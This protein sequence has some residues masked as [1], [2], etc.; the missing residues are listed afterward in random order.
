M[1]FCS[2]HVAIRRTQHPYHLLK[3]GVLSVGQGL[4]RRP[5]VTAS[6]MYLSRQLHSVLRTPLRRVLQAALETPGWMLTLG[7][8]LSSRAPP[9]MRGRVLSDRHP[10]TESVPPPASRLFFHG[11]GGIRY[12][13]DAR[14]AFGNGWLRRLR[15][16]EGLGRGGLEAIHGRHEIP[17]VGRHRTVGVL[18]PARAVPAVGHRGRDSF[19]PG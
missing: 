8:R 16:Q 12:F 2:Q 14:A 18:P 1:S 13:P 5:T 17:T 3:T 4:I 9:F 10:E 11:L 19:D 7:S 15:A 6:M